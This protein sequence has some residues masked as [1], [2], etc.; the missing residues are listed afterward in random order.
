[1]EEDKDIGGIATGGLAGAAIG[2]VAG[3]ALPLAV[4]GGQRVVRGVRNVFGRRAEQLAL[5]KGGVPDARVA[6]KKLAE[7]GK[8]VT[9]KPAQEAIRQ[10]I[11]EADVAL[12]KVS[13]ATDKTKMS[14]MLDIRQS[15]L[16]NKRVTDRA[17]D[18]VG[19]TFTTKIAGPI[20]KLNRESGKR[21]DLVARGLAGKKVD[22]TSALTQFAD[23]LER[24]GITM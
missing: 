2:G 11:P 4:A 22:S 14:K 15:Q 1:M 10:G 7:S 13:T 8:L 5:V 6:A 18:V 3:A 23:D 17:T 19:D 24:A 16:T 20:Q 12:I 9:D 21:L